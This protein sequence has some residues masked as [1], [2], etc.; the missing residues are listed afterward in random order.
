MPNG[1]YAK[2]GQL[3]H[4]TFPYIDDSFVVAH[5]YND[6]QL[7]L[8]ALIAE[9]RKAGFYVHLEKS[10]LEPTQ[11]LTFLGFNRNKISMEVSL[12]EE[13][14]TNFFSFA[15]L[16]IQERRKVKIWKVAALIGMMTAY[17]QGLHFACAHIK[18]LEINK[19]LALTRAKVNYNKNMII[20]EQG[21]DDINWWLDNIRGSPQKI[22]LEEAD[23]EIATGWGAQRGTEDTGG[24]WLPTESDDHINILE[25]KA[26]LLGLLSLAKVRNTHIKLFTDNN[27][28]LAYLR[29][30]PGN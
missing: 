18:S 27:T 17:S 28:A 26:I 22:Q 23:M 9:F 16:I 20:S 19:N 2:L 21:L 6:C 11:K 13:K 15:S 14:I 24:R 25:L 7:T 3:G 30:T 8:Q 29:R 12:T 10:V 5:N 4:I 1:I